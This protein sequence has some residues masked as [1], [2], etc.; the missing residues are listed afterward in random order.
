MIF[1]HKVLTKF[2][3]RLHVDLSGSILHS[4]IVEVKLLEHKNILICRDASRLCSS[5]AELL[6]TL[7]TD[8]SD[9]E[10]V[11]KQKLSEVKFRQIMEYFKSKGERVIKR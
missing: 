7:E 2:L 11:V 1:V 3:D 9:D 10:V 5:K 4:C 8:D 6:R